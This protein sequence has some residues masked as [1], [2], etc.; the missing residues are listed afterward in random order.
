MKLGSSNFAWMFPKTRLSF[1]MCMV[2][3]DLVSRSLEIIDLISHNSGNN[4]AMT[5]QFCMKVPH[6]KTTF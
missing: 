4:E 3:L 6:Q 1:S 2:D 5:F